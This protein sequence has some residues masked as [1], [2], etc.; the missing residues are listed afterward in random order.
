MRPGKVAVAARKLMVSAGIRP[1]AA[2]SGEEEGMHGGRRA[3]ALGAP[4]YL[5]VVVVVGVVAHED[6]AHVEHHARHEDVRDLLPLVGLGCE[7][8]KVTTG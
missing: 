7:R 4:G 6:E 5:L 3:R 1:R 8:Q 2:R